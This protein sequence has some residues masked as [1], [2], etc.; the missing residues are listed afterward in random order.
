MI[1]TC[2]SII[3]SLILAVS[4]ISY[5][6]EFGNWESYYQNTL[7]I[8][9]P[10]K[11]LLLAQ[12]YF[13]REKKEGCTAADLGAGTGRDSLF[14]L[15]HGWHVLALD[16][17]KLSIDIILNR[18]HSSY[19]PNLETMVVP[20]SEMILPSELDLI[21]ASY[22]LPFCKPK[23][24]DQCWKM[25]VDQLAIGGRFSGHFFGEKDEW[26]ANPNLTIH[27]YE[28]MRRLFEEQ[29]IIEY[30]QIEDGLIPCANDEMKHWHVYH[31]VAKKVR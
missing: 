26:A 3:V 6:S 17:E 13:Q 19:L 30:L 23:D 7:T 5:A 21:N 27:S 20:F 25:I 18:V 4:T 1:K 14:L 16:A 28:E 29:F 12:K 2:S 15:H 24:F 31:V 8:S 22:S 11:T 9:D 10:H